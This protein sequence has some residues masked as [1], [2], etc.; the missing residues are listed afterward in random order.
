MISKNTGAINIEGNININITD[1]VYSAIYS[2]GNEVNISGTPVINV[3]TEMTN[4]RGAQYAI[5]GIGVNILGGTL[6]LGNNEEVYNA[7]N[8]LCSG[9][10][11][12][13]KIG[14]NTVLTV[15]SDRSGILARGGL[16]TVTDNA[17]VKMYDTVDGNKVPA[18]VRGPAVSCGKFVADKN[19]VIDIVS[20][21]S[22]ISAATG[23]SEITDNAVVNIAVDATLSKEALSF[24]EKISVHGD[25]EVN[26]SVLNGRVNG[27]ACYNGT[28]EIY[29]NA[30]VKIYGTDKAFYSNLNIYGNSYLKVE[31]SKQGVDK[32]AAI[33][34]SAKVDITT[35]SSKP[36]N[37]NITLEPKRG[38]TYM[39]KMGKDSESAEVLYYASGSVPQILPSV[40]YFYAEPS[41]IMPITIE[42]ND[43]ERNRFSRSVFILKAETKKQ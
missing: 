18:T 25:S 9:E 1:C 35:T 38:K 22:G 31:G 32:N 11:K 17:K 28:A 27:F 26:I 43:S 14:G 3:D 5:Y 4:E 2:Y 42:A 40:S 10:N 39:M 23:P 41:D 19:A 37:G 6:V 29:D 33:S 16:V 30:S 12:E 36:F 15:K 8:V 24:K 21:E 34:A 7:G 13:F 20:K